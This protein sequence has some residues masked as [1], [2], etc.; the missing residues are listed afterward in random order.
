MVFK[1]L[2]TLS[3]HAPAPRAPRVPPSE[4]D[5]RSNYAHI[6]PWDAARMSHNGVALGYD[7]L[8]WGENDRGDPEMVIARATVS[9]FEFMVMTNVERKF[10]HSI[11]WDARNRGEQIRRRR[12]IEELNKKPWD[13]LDEQQRN[14]ALSLMWVPEQPKSPLEMLAMQLEDD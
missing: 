1:K 14:F 11:G 8:R 10:L 4:V 2:M 5:P 6:L 7:L 9:H 13:E 3:R 12:I